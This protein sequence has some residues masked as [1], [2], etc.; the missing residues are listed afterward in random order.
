MRDDDNR[1]RIVLIWERAGE[2]KES[3]KQGEATVSVTQ[4]GDAQAPV[5]RVVSAGFG[6]TFRAAG[7]GGQP[8]ASLRNA[9]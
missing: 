8:T 2:S 9:A 4:L 3:D 7:A 6:Q 1:K 5:L